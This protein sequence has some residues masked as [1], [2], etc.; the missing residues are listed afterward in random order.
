MKRVTFNLTDDE[1]SML[2]LVIKNNRYRA[3]K[4]AK[5]VYLDALYKAIASIAPK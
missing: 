1:E 3:Y 2:K 5:I 4:D